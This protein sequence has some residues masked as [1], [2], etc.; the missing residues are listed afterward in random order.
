MT[1]PQQSP[2]K[3]LVNCDARGGC[4]DAG[5]PQPAADGFT[6]VARARYES[7]GA[8]D[9]GTE[10]RAEAFAEAEGDAVKTVAVLFQPPFQRLRSV[11]STST[12]NDG[13]PQPGAI[14]MRGDGRVLRARPLVYL[15]AVA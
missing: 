10:G 12:S 1:F 2:E 13:F 7:G 3:G 6:D 11:L 15:L 8:N 4:D 5:L 9:Y 14:Q